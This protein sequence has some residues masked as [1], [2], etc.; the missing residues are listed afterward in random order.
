MA[1]RET[2]ILSLSKDAPR[3]FP[4]FS[5]LMLHAPEPS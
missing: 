5:R 1:Q 2:L 4:F 3:G